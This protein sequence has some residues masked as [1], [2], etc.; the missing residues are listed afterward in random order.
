MAIIILLVL[1][2]LAIADVNSN[3]EISSNSYSGCPENE[4]QALLVF[5]EGLI[6]DAN[7]LASWDPHHH[8][9]CCIW[10]GVVCGN[11][12]G[13]ILSL[14]LSFPPLDDIVDVDSYLMSM[15]KGKINPCLSNLKH[16]RYLDLSNNA[17]EGLLPYQL[18]N[19]SNLESLN[20]RGEDK[21]NE[22]GLLY[23]EN[24]QWLSG[25]SLLKHLDLSLVDLSRASNWLQL[26]NT[27]LP[28]LEELHLSN[29]FLQLGRPLLNVNLSTLAVLDLSY[30]FFTNQM[31]LGWVSKLNSLVV[32]NLAGSDFH[33]P[34]PDFLQNMTSLRHLDLSYNN[35]KSSISCAIFNIST[36][37][38]LYLSWNDLEG[39]LPRAVGKL[40]N[41]R[42]IFLSSI[43]SNCSSHRFESLAFASCQ[44]SGQLTDQLEHFK[45]LKELSLNDNSI[46]GPIPTSLGKL[47]NLEKVEIYNNLLEG[48]VSEKHFANHTKLRFFEGSDN[49]LVLRANP[50]WVPPF[51]LRLLGLRSLHIG[52]SFPLWLRSQKHLEYL[53]ISNS[54]ISDTIPSCNQMYG[55]F[56]YLPQTSNDSC[57]LD[58]SFNNFSGPLPQISMGSNPSMI[59]LSNNY[60]LGPLFHFLCFQLNAI[61]GTRKLQSLHLH[62][63]K[64]HGEIPLSL[65][66]CRELVAINLGKNELDGD[67]PG[68][69]GQDLTNLIILI[70]RSNKFGGS[71]RDH[72]CALTSLHIFDLA[73]NNFFGSIPR[74]ISNFTAMVRGNG[75]WGN[76]ILYAA[77]AGPL[78][79]SAS[80]V[81]KG[82]LLEYDSTL[83]LV[84]VLDFSRNK[85]SGKIPHE[86]TSLQGLQSLNLFQN[87]LSGKI[88]ENI[89]GIIPTSSQLESFN[90]S[91]Y[92][93]NH[94]CGS[95]LKDCKG[96]GNEHGV[97][98]GGRGIGEGQEVNWFYVS[99]PLGFVSG[100]WCVLGPLV[101]SRQWRIMYFR[102]L[103]QMWWKV[104][105]FVAKIK[106]FF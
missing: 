68:W 80:V 74:C 59:D 62:N 38:E 16:L 99:M 97:R 17:F 50:Y 32:L 88:P 2:I 57:I 103:E 51:Q 58:L 19:L 70:L 67:L 23:V 39:K 76:A 7:R 86:V 82:Q 85:F 1:I 40:C 15:L 49:S 30:N 78:S 24:L 98:T 106:F 64:L 28:S 41:L 93:G 26:V 90:E 6:D 69:L 92:A 31:N 84:K 100:F 65:K 34:I 29:C 101:I 95:P 36:L 48:V 75:S 77:I 89:S 3:N 44:L 18:G 45:N 60:F 43:L 55:Q 56:S 8:P 33:G 5:K 53:D 104:C 91:C 63:N 105:D 102:F 9:D 79:E 54:T 47:A 13:H 12:T 22:A 52:P 27:R 61:I 10:F 87:H 20:L 11:R 42:S 83:N 94:L 21:F 96:S 4:K 46:F 37:N 25:L 66:N 73:D 14:N 71:I 72:L 81:M 35:F